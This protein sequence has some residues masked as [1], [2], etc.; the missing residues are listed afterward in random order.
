MIRSALDFFLTMNKNFHWTVNIYLYF[1][2]CFSVIRVV[3]VI[4]FDIVI[5]H[6][7]VCLVLLNTSMFILLCTYSVL[8]KKKKIIGIVLPIVVVV[9]YF[10]RNL[11]NTDGKMPL[12]FNLFMSVCMLFIFVWPLFVRKNG[13]STFSYL[14]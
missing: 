14:K 8:I 4:L 10:L 9:L 3:W 6:S 5:N 12:Y 7:D 2:I 1:L 11:Y 13:K